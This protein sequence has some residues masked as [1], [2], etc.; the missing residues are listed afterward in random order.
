MV[1]LLHEYQRMRKASQL[2]YCR[3][4]RPGWT[5]NPTLSF[6][7]LSVIVT[8][9]SSNVAQRLVSSSGCQKM[10]PHHRPLLGQALAVVALPGMRNSG[11]LCGGSVV[12]TT[13]ACTAPSR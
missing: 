1:T 13:K 2:K 12:D 11:C 4:T 9:N 8:I 3:G 10:L 6:L 5:N 7:S